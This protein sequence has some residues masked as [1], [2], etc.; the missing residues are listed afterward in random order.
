MKR[1]TIVMMIMTMIMI[2]K[3]KMEDHGKGE[4]IGIELIESELPLNSD[5]FPV[6]DS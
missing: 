4:E 6:V 3:H 5:L 1:A 2:T